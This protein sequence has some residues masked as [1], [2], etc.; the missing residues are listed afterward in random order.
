[1]ARPVDRG[2]DGHTTDS[3]GRRQ[4]HRAGVVTDVSIAVCSAA[5]AWRTDN[6][7]RRSLHGPTFV[8]SDHPENDLPVHRIDRKNM[9]NSNKSG[10]QLGE[11]FLGP[12]LRR[13]FTPRTKANQ[14]IDSSR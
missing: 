7:P 5:P 2:H 14:P 3:G 11:A 6:A 12:N 13:P 1:M 9:G 4:V 10:S 8:S